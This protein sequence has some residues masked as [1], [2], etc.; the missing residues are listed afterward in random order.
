MKFSTLIYH[1]LPDSYKYIDYGK[2]QSTSSYSFHFY[3]FISIHH[4]IQDKLKI[5]PV[6]TNI[7]THSSVLIC[8][9]LLK[10]HE[11]LPEADTGA[12]LSVLYYFYF[13]CYYYYYYF[14]T[15]YHFI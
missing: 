3:H 1:T 8:L 11:R 4:N 10:R 13:Y 7:L 14:I 5:S 6:Q 15:S 2:R 12:L 9:S